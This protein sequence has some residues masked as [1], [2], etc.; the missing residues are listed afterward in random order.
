MYYSMITFVTK[1]S[2]IPQETV[3][4]AAYNIIMASWRDP[5]IIQTKAS[6]VILDSFY[7]QCKK[8]WLTGIA[9]NILPDHIH[10]L[11][12]HKNNDISQYV[13][14]IKWH[15][16]FL[17]NKKLNITKPWWGRQS[18]L[19][20][21]WYSKTKIVSKEHLERATK[22]INRNHY[23]HAKKRWNQLIENYEKHLKTKLL[24]YN[25]LL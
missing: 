4:L 18:T 5:V 7:I 1:Y 23:K 22:Y 6:S 16:S 9:C 25:R 14:I 13:R 11:I 19:R 20:A 12:W 24:Q 3:A 10:L 15:S 17:Y 2:R 21:E 8:F